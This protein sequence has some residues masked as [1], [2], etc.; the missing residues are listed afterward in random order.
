L[1]ESEAGA[2]LAGRLPF[3]GGMTGTG[4]RSDLDFIRF[5]SV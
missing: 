2:L 5:Y 4:L 3:A 1:N